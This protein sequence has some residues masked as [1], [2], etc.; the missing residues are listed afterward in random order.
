MDKIEKV[1]DCLGGDFLKWFSLKIL[2][3]PLLFLNDYC[4]QTYFIELAMV[5][6]LFSFFFVK[7][8]RS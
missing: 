1:K 7:K 6:F 4:Q 5:V 8:E 2:P 3:D